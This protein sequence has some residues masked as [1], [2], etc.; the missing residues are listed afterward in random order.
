MDLGLPGAGIVPGERRE[1]LGRE[2]AVEDHAARAEDG[3]GVQGG[4][5]AAFAVVAHED[6]AEL[7]AG[8]DH[9]LLLFRPLSDRTVGVLQVARLGAGS[10]VAP[11][12]DDTVAEE[13]AVGF[14]GPS[15]EVH[16]GHFSADFAVGANHGGAANVGARPDHGTFTQDHW[17]FNVAAGFNPRAR[18]DDNV[19]LGGVE[20]GGADGGVLR[21]PH[22][23][24][25]AIGGGV[26]TCGK[27]AELPGFRHPV[28]VAVDLISQ[29]DE[30]VVGISVV[31]RMSFTATGTPAKRPRLSPAF[32]RWSISSARF[33]AP[34]SLTHV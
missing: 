13:S 8:I 9:G 24:F 4:P 29:L 32:L 3:A 30:Q 21:H 16:I 10:E 18:A 6:P 17:T 11:S 19:A 5:D 7:Q 22:P 12:A 34:S 23:V 1:V 2:A 26:R 28:V 31:Q 14:V 15:L 20:A 33:N 27:G 25:R